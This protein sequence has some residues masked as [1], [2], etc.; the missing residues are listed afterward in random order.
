MTWNVTRN[1]PLYLKIAFKLDSRTAGFNKILMCTVFIVG[2][3][4]FLINH[5]WFPLYTEKKRE[6]LAAIPNHRVG[7]S[8]SHSFPPPATD[9]ICCIGWQGCLFA[10]VCPIHCHRRTC[11]QCSRMSGRSQHTETRGP[12]WVARLETHLDIPGSQNSQTQK[13]STIKMIQGSLPCSPG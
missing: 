11:C 3:V 1:P 13:Y 5:W 7:R 12:V 8:H 9:D 10:P 4:H 2:T 6:C